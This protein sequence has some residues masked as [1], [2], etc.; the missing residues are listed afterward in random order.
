MKD[1]QDTG[2][3][4]RTSST[5]SLIFY[6]IFAHLDLDQADQID[7]DLG[8]GYTTLNV[9]RLRLPRILIESLLYGI[10][11]E[12]NR[13]GECQWVTLTNMYEGTFIIRALKLL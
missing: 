10:T 3:E 1:V 13:R 2:E 4:K 12:K 5:F 6:I 11:E 7:L 8:S 9:R